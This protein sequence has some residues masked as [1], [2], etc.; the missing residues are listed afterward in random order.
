MPGRAGAG[1][2]IERSSTALETKMMKEHLTGVQERKRKAELDANKAKLPCINRYF[3]YSVSASTV[4]EVTASST[5][6]DNGTGCI[7]DTLVGPVYTDGSGVDERAVAH[8]FLSPNTEEHADN[9]QGSLPVTSSVAALWTIDA[10][11]QQYCMDV[12]PDFFRNRDGNYTMSTRQ[13]KDRTRKLCD[14]AF[15]QVS[16]N[17]ES[18]ERPWL[19]YSPSTGCVFCFVCKLFSPNSTTALAGRG[20]DSWDHIG[21][22]GDHERS[23]EHRHALTIYTTRL[24]RTQMLDKHRAEE[25]IKERKY[26]AEVLK[27]VVSAIKFLTTRGL[28]LIGTSETFGSLND[29]NYLGCLEFLAE[30]D[31]FLGRHIDKYGNAVHGSTSYLSSTICEEFIKLMADKIK[32]DIVDELKLVKYFS[33]S[34]DSTTDISH[35]DQ[36]TFIVHYV[37]NNCTPVERFLRPPSN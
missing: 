12:G 36:L 9:Q 10:N 29:G 24:S 13:Y 23:T 16:P 1:E 19:I 26:W 35:T 37:L 14:I 20:F 3:N 27:R 5:P 11:T 25:H 17:G 31:H 7:I 6:G 30:Y 32:Q 22:L 34:V 15:N 18:I 4:N 21:R 8:E 33:F 2:F 28:A